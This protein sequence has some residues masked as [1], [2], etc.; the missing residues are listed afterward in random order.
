[1]IHIKK[2]MQLLAI[3]AV[4]TMCFCLIH[5]GGKVFAKDIRLTAESVNIKNARPENI[6]G[7]VYI[8]LRN[9][10]EALGWEVIW[11]AQSKTVTCTNDNRVIHFKPD[12]TMVEIDGKQ[13]IM[14]NPPVI[15]RNTSY[16]PKKFITDE[17]GLKVRWN[18]K[19]N[20]II[21]SD[22]DTTS[23]TVNG[24]SNIIIVGDGMII[25]IFEPC[26]IHAVSDMISLADRLIASNNAQ[27][28]LHK[29][30][31]ILDSLS[32]EENPDIYAYVMNNRANAYQKLAEHR[33]TGSNIQS[34][35][36]SYQEALDYYIEIDDTANYSIIL[37]NLGSAYKKLYD[38]TGNNTYLV[39]A[40]VYYE[41]ALKY[42]NLH[43]YPMDYALIQYN[44]G[45][46]YYELGFIDFSK[47][48]FLA[49]KD[50]FEKLLN[51]Y[52]LDN[53]PSCYA[54][55]QFHLGDICSVVEELQYLEKKDIHKVNNQEKATGNFNEALKVWTAESHPLN[56]AKVHKYFGDMYIRYYKIFENADYL[57]MAEKEYEEALEFYSPE[58]HPFLYAVANYQL[59]SL[60]ILLFRFETGDKYLY[61]AARAYENSLKVLN[62]AEY[63]RYYSKALSAVEKLKN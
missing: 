41:K 54:T 22:E 17:F 8:P 27:E 31:E 26:D 21:T 42:Y 25:N 33:D 34:A 12:S 24:G 57:I 37:N 30:N 36:D 14:D 40:S 49:S 58:R 16:V 39:E 29:Y 6:N 32:K 55:I 47:R 10:F 15:M 18:K 7:T 4:F 61:E 52:S 56:Y 51:T 60:K 48:C 3:S 43:R 59:G 44:M 63:P 1:M 20:I 5:T 13:S 2:R 23:V 62:F 19:D 38:I 28:A 53:A 35:I 45:K 46:V 50:V 11:D 9:I